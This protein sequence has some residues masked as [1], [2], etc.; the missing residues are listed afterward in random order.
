MSI[1]DM[2]FGGN[3]T[4]RP[5][6]L[7]PTEIV[8]EVPEEIKPIQVAP[9]HTVEIVCE[10]PDETTPATW[11]K[12]DVKLAPDDVKYETTTKERKRSL[13]IKDVKPEDAGKYVCEV[14]PHRTTAAVEVVKPTEEGSLSMNICRDFVWSM[15]TLCL[16]CFIPV[17]I[18][19]CL[20]RLKY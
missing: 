14:G 16:E 1:K 2:L 9:S 12:D 11:Y 6:Y 19:A 7:S 18:S 17:S 20:S 15:V 5:T 13:V 8:F 3:V 10:T 4:L